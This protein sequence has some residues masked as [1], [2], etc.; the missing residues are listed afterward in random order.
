M[1]KP[2]LRASQLITTYGPG[3]MVDLPEDAVITAGLDTWRYNRNAPIPTV[4]EPRL[5]GKLETVLGL[6]GLT[7]RKP[8]PAIEEKGFTPDVAAYC[9]PE[10][11]IS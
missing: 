11:V 9:F 4:S 3:A 8:P 10:W 6:G 1:G 7:L 5:I 2:E